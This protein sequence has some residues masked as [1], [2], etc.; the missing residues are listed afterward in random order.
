MATASLSLGEVNALDEAGFVAVFGGLFEH[1][2]WI[3]RDSWPARPFS[4][5]RDLL[6]RMIATMRAA[7]RE[8]QLALIRAHPDLAGRLAREGALTASS[9]AEQASAG[10]DR[11]DSEEAARFGTYNDLYR[12]R[13]GF[14]FII[15]ARLNNKREIL[16][17]FERRLQST[18]EEETATAL[19]EIEKIAA[20]RLAAILPEEKP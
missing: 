14:P 8:R 1:S 17:A 19:F 11:L 16:R 15:C 9:N 20:L 5:G 13:F 3:A 2:P 4:S 7:P 18:P 12:E 10:L 6:A